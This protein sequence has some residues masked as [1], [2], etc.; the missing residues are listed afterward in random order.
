MHTT[1]GNFTAAYD[2]LRE[3]T[4]CRTQVAVAKFLG[5]RH[6]SVLAARHR[7]SMPASWLLT[8]LRRLSVNP[9]WIETGTGRR[10]IE[11]FGAEQMLQYLSSPISLEELT[12]TLACVIC[13]GCP[14]CHKDKLPSCY[15]GFAAQAAAVSTYIRGVVQELKEDRSSCSALMN[16]AK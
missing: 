2:R 3:V 9:D 5:I 16:S 10:Y 8:L 6:T 12:D 1:T 4:G 14:K 11:S 7:G 13:S 15:A